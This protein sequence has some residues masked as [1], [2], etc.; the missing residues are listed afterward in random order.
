[1][2]AAR[3]NAFKW[4]LTDGN[5]QMQNLDSGLIDSSYTPHIGNPLFHCHCNIFYSAHLSL[6]VSELANFYL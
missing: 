5:G 3:L 1:M 2:A 4:P 6:S